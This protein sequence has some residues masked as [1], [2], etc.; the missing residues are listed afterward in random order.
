MANTIVVCNKQTY[1]TCLYCQHWFKRIVGV[2]H[3]PDT[4]TAY[5]VHVYG[6]CQT[7]VHH[8]PDTYYL[9]WKNDE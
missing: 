8:M 4:C 3:M 6:I 2:W 5:G 9:Q 7:P 1:L